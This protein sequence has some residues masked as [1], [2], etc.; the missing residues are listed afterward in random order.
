MAT[1]KW[2]KDGTVEDEVAVPIVFVDLKAK[3]DADSIEC[4]MFQCFKCQSMI[5]GSRMLDGLCE[6]CFVE[7]TRP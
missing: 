7:G 4:Y 2:N 3:W 1:K 6:E 5:R